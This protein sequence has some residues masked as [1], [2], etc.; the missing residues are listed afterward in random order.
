MKN[1][2]PVG[3]EQWS[4]EERRGDSLCPR[5]LLSHPSCPTR[6]QV[7]GLS[8]GSVSDMLSRPK[9]W[10]KLTQKGREPFIRM[11][12]W[13]SDQLGQA[14]SQ[15]PSASQGEYP[16]GPFKGCCQ[17]PRTVA[18]PHYSG[19]CNGTCICFTALST[20][21]SGP[22]APAIIIAPLEDCSGF[23]GG[24][25]TSLSCFNQADV[26]VAGFKPV[27]ST[28]ASRGNNLHVEPHPLIPVRN[29]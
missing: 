25:P 9:P 12:L 28:R 8:Q 22:I 14:V 21:P 6:P 20:P 13:L 17:L 10:S 11:Q 7:L 5:G 3:T 27:G 19:L 4:W 1:K 29:L 15:Q 16:Q 18:S 24:V 26:S 2:C 23:L